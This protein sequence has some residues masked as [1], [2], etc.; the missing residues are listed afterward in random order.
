MH[1][2]RNG[3]HFEFGGQF[4]SYIDYYKSEAFLMP[5]K[6]FVDDSIWGFFSKKLFYVDVLKLGFFFNQIGAILELAAI[7]TLKRKPQRWK[8]T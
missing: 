3:R 6:T 5:D 1:F 4:G 8:H 2:P 7:V